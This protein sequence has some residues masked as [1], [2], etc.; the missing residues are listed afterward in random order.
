MSLLKSL[1]KRIF[2]YEARLILRK[3]KPKVIAIT[4]SVGKT[5][6]RDAIYLVLSKKYFVRKSERSF[7]TELGVPLTVI[8]CSQGQGTV[9]QWLKNVFIGLWVIIRTQHYP[10][11]L[12]LE[13]DGDRPGDFQR[14]STWFSPDILVVTAITDVPSHV[15]IFGSTDALISEKK[16]LL[17]ALRADGMVVYDGDDQRSR[18]Y[19]SAFEG[20]KVSAGFADGSDII[21]SRFTVL[22]GNTDAGSVPTGMSFEISAGGICVPIS[23]FGSVG[24]HNEYACLLACAIGL[25][26][27]MSVQE[28]AMS[29]G[30]YK[31][32][33]G[34]MNILS[35]IKGT[36]IIDDSY[37]SS[38]AAMH[39]A[40]ELFRTLSVSG[41]TGSRKIAV[42]GDMLE[43]GK[44]SAD[45]HKKLAPYLSD[46]SL[47]IC[48][49]I[50]MR[51]A[52]E[53]LL[54]LGFDE[55]NLLQVDT[56]EEAGRELQERLQPGDIV[57]VKG[58]Q[59]MR[60]ERVVEEVMRHPQDK[61]ILLVRQEPEW[62]RRD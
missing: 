41:S 27:G 55:A 8:G 30:Q 40:L 22:Y 57:L 19:A 49:G 6:T 51:M 43:L 4:G 12:I 33:P 56:A 53:E 31:S 29:L 54:S 26:L 24:I 62:Q 15:E 47:V 1:I 39:Q 2:Q 34:R 11:W 38:P 36:T 9:P 17:Q 10:E 37:N 3:Y 59:G 16:F 28:C 48:T 42:I 20:T 7:T 14:L 32:L 61:E 13:I 21:G 45:E 5:S 18:E 58:S 44:Y 46:L 35:G 52:A 60:M 50:R 25:Q 23:I